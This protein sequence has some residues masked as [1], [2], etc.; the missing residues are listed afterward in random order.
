MVRRI[1]IWITVIGLAVPIHTL[2][3]TYQQLWKQVEDAQEKDLPKTA[4][5]HLQLIETKAQKEKAYGQLLK[6][7][8][9][10]S[11][12]LS[13][14]SPDSLLPAVTRLEKQLESVSDK[15]LEA[16][17]AAVLAQ[18]YLDNEQLGEDRGERCMAYYQQAMAHPDVLASTQAGTYAPFVVNGKDSEAF[19]NDLL[20]VIGYEF[21]EWGWLE[22]YYQKSGNRRALCHLAL[23]TADTIQELD[24]LA[25]LYGDLPEASVIAQRRQNLW[26]VQTNPTFQASLS[27]QVLMPGESQTVRLRS[28][29]N[30][31]QLTM[32]VF[33]TRLTGDTRL[34]PDKAEDYSQIKKRMTELEDYALTK[35]FQGHA[36]DEF[37]EDSLA[38][39]G[40][41]AGVYL[42]EFSCPQTSTPSRALCFV[43]GLRLMT[44]AMPNETMRYVVV[45]AHTGQPV[46]KATLCLVY[47]G[48]KKQEKEKHTCNELGEVLV[49][50]DTR[51]PTAVYIS[52]PTD[53]FC[54]SVN[55][56]GRY[57]YYARQYNQEQV[58]L[59]TD[60]SLYRPGQSVYVSA[61]VWKELSAVAQEAVSNKSL[62]LVLRDANNEVVAEQQLTTDRFGKCST[63]FTLPNGLLNGEFSIRTSNAVVDFQVE[64]YKRPTFQVEFESYKQRY[65]QGDTVQVQG[66]ALSYAGIPVQG[67]KVH[68][69]VKRRVAFWWMSYS[70]YWNSGYLGR[71]LNDEVMNEGDAV[72][73]DDGTFQVAMPM[74]LPADLGEHAMF[75]HFVV[76]ADV[77]DM[78]GETH[79]GSLSLPLGNKPTALQ[80]NLPRQIRRDQLPEVTFTRCNAAGSPIEGTVRYRLDGGK[81]KT[82]AANTAVSVLPKS[83]RSGEHRVEAECEQDKID[84]TFVVFGLDDKKPATLTHDWFYVSD[85]QFPRDG[86]PVTVQ[87]GSS[88]PDVH[89]VYGLFAGN[90]VI[91]SGTVERDGQLLNRQLTYQESYGNGL[92]LTYAWVKEGKCYMHRQTITRPLPDKQ[93]RVTW[94]T[95]RDRLTP[96]Q[97]EEWR[98]KVL[99]PDGSPADATLMAVLYDKSLDQLQ[100]HQW[101]FVPR[102]YMEQPNT[103][104]QCRSWRALRWAGS[105]KY[106]LID[107][108]EY[109]YSHFDTSVYPSY[110]SSLFMRGMGE[111]YAARP[112][113]LLSNKTAA[114]AMDESAV[115]MDESAVANADRVDR[116]AASAAQ[117]APAEQAAASE[118]SQPQEEEVPLRENLNETAF[119]YPSL[120]T[121]EQGGVA[122]KFTLPESLT[123]WRFMG[124]AHTTDMMYG[125]IEDEAVAR[126]TVM[127][128]PNVPRFVRIGDEVQISARIFNTADHAVSG[129]AKL[130]LLTATDL[131]TVVEQQQPFQVEAGQT[132]AVTF[133]LSS[134][135]LSESLLVCRVLA[136]GDGFSD[137]EQH[138]LPVLPDREYVTKTVPYTQH[139]PGVKTIDLTGL[140][141]QGTTQQKLTVEY[142]H[143]PAWLMVQSLS[144]IGQP[145]EHS[146]IDQAAS[147]YSN[148]LAGVLLSQSPQ[149]KRVF[150]QWQLE[151]GK[152]Q[153]LMSQLQ[154]DEALK[155]LLLS[156][157]PWVAAADREAEQRQRLSD[158]F[159]ENVISHRLQAALQKLVSL[160]N[161]DGSFSWYPGM[162][163]STSVTVAVMEMLVRLNRMAGQQ[164]DISLLQDEAD[165]YLD[166]EMIT[167]VK[168]MKKREKKGQRQQFPSFTAL[169]WLY[170][171][172]LEDRQLPDDAQAASDYLVNLLKKDIKRQ[173]IYEK[174]LTAVVL[175]KRG[176]MKNAASYV[177]SLKEYSVF[178]E[179]MGRYYDT[180]RASYSWYDYRIPTE[181]AAVEAIQLVTPQDVQTVDEMRRWLLQEKRTQAW[182][183]PIS[184]INAIYAFLMN[185][186]SLLAP[187]EQSVLAL[188][189]K[190]LDM[191]SATAGVGYVKTAIEHPQA[192]TFTATKSSEGTSWGAVYAQFLQPTSAVEA[193]Q[194]GIT[195]VRELLTTKGKKL[196]RPLRVGDKVRVRITIHSS[197][198]LDFVQVIDRRAACMEP[199]QQLS[200]YRQGAYVSPKDAATHYFYNGLSKGKHVIDTDYYIDRAGTYE[201]G[202]CTVQCAYAPEYHATTRSVKLTVNKE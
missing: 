7:T 109:S 31:Q 105:Y 117:E 198:D 127:I 36:P 81:W 156:E 175:A 137:G 132:A 2:S 173:T 139:T 186:Q 138:Y 13:E 181:V 183:T 62:K 201:T 202:T 28:L 123:T 112:M 64:E 30:I 26:T 155:E 49:K 46:P 58:S 52:S 75:Y 128:Q 151:Q 16:V 42:I 159:D 145:S 197:R 134:S 57:T 180:H 23:R 176:E 92:L 51:R 167:L 14:V 184:T 82:C 84:M 162:D 190:P 124:V 189:G 24:S 72:T 125:A 69:V 188:D 142:T 103:S 17:Y 83:L 78:A 114:V 76:D 45:D 178:T 146:A 131:A 29:R 101:S 27:Q 107:I 87:V 106:R 165:R 67:A 93:L 74:L 168:E 161:S 90:E 136:S 199:L 111:S 59:F 71:G 25:A 110:Y 32:R 77:T 38:L 20:S 163:G 96:G 113:R 34:N 144:V 157:T 80:C 18:I 54:P 94:E 179:E 11:R 141:P 149:V 194:S 35:T 39:K 148:S 73:T 86:S 108:P 40:L 3:Q 5:R 8:L 169:R 119:C 99:Q 60:R 104:W 166:T 195:V 47:N 182:D 120:V 68:Y 43:S 171:T 4:I 6:S 122:V 135:S 150:Q 196:E 66:K 10:H 12:L 98:L 153:T 41:A 143:N 48:K 129:Q 177:K 116:V 140:F 172:A 50:Q 37:F 130:V 185:Q 33:R 91:E 70:W 191:P 89:I 164:A 154:K 102:S 95:F 85:S 115:A 187:K 53:A 1:I 65:Q 118:E 126:K 88:D 22:K 100:E 133:T 21:K 193:S 174:A 15:A 44:Q 61:I 55:N 147:Y 97:Q 79:H 158:F 63:V 192:S 152:E 9:L 121:D 170:I 160:Q 56:Y 19:G 200:G